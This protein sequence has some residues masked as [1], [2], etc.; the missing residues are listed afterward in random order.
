MTGDH[1]IPAYG[2]LVAGMID[3]TLFPARGLPGLRF[4][5]FRALL[6]QQHREDGNG[7]AYQEP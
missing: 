2:L 6:E 3:G 7:H 5:Y 4:P 1:R